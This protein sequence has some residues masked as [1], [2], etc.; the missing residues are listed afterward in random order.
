MI[1]LITVIILQRR[2]GGNNIITL[3]FH[4]NII[5]IIPLDRESILLKEI[6][7]SI[8]ATLNLKPIVDRSFNKLEIKKD[9]K[10]KEAVEYESKLFKRGHAYYEFTH[11]MEHVSEDK[12]LIFMN[13]VINL[14]VH[15]VCLI[16][17]LLLQ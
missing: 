11:K 16:I 8:E 2:I 6:M 12:E 17:P 9:C 13:K 7:P 10:L 4:Y 3:C 14:L 1:I 15:Y 5:I